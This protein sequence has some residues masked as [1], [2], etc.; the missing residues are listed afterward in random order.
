MDGTAIYLSGDIVKEDAETFFN[1]TKSIER[2]A[3]ILNSDG[4]SAMAGLR[5]GLRIRE[6]G[7]ATAVESDAVCMSACSDIWLAGSTRFAG[8]TAHIGFHTAYFI[9]KTNLKELG[10]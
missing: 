3:V 1:M 7:Y 5:I 10:N 4:G 9:K 2:A 6:K 8:P